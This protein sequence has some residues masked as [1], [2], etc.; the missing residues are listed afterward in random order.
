MSSMVPPAASTAALTFSHTCLVCA[1]ISPMPAM[2]P[3]GLREV[4]P[5]MN[6]IRPRAS[7]M[8][9]CEKWPF[10]LLILSELICFFGIVSSLR[11]AAECGSMPPQPARGRE[12]N[13]GCDTHRSQLARDVP[14]QP[15]LEQ[16]HPDRQGHGRLWRGSH[17]R[18]RSG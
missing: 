17:G 12:T 1:S 16:R 5:E 3:S 18:D 8:V 11:V 10:G 14:G 7:I 15:A 2:V 9:A 6:T 4:M 13:D